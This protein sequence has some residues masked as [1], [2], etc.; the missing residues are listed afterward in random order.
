MLHGGGTMIRT[1]VLIPVL[2][3]ATVKSA[4]GQLVQC[5]QDSPERRGEPG[6]TIVADKR[7]P[8][9]PQPPAL[10]HSDEFESRAAARHAGGWA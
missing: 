4:Q 10:W 8:S 5:S 9:P 7:L 3:L 6:C 1:V 2:W